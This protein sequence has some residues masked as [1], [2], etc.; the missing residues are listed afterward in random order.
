[1]K[2]N[3]FLSDEEVK[4]SKN[5]SG[6]GYVIK[7]I[8]NY[9]SY[10]W[11]NKKILLIS[12]N[13]LKEKKISENFLDN[14][15][16]YISIKKLNN[17]RVRLFNDLN[18][19]NDFKFHYYNLSKEFLNLIVGNELA[20]QKRI[21]LSIQLPNDASSLLP[22]HSDVWSGDSPYEVVVWLPFVDCFKTKS[23][24]ILPPKKNEKFNKK[25]YKFNGASSEKIFK[26]IKSDIK[27]LTVNKGEILI[28]NQSLPHGNRVNKEKTTRWS[29]NCRFK[30]L[31]SP[32]GDKKIG[33]F[34]IP[35][36]TK[37][38]ST[39]GMNYSKPNISK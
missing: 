34:F 39:I 21:N 35:I 13:I 20:M 4:I 1:M 5:F 7:S 17:F 24:F 8:N 30:S 16:K 11:I 15:H 10:E 23:M 37:V 3:S 31:Y 29:M 2:I 12:K 9:S 36:T 38:A 26:E 14:A 6:N 32:Y 19:L 33:E 27:W 28:F 18:K 22:V 25:F